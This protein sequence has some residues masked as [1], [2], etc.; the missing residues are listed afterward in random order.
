MSKAATA[1]TKT[2]DNAINF[3]RFMTLSFRDLSFG[4]DTM[5]GAPDGPT[6]DFMRGVIRWLTHGSVWQETESGFV[7]G[8]QRRTYSRI[9]EG[10][11]DSNS[12]SRISRSA[13]NLKPTWQPTKVIVCTD[14]I[15]VALDRSEERRVGKECRSRKLANQEKKKKKKIIDVYSMSVEEASRPGITR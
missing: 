4:R 3:L 6:A 9:M 2:A 7:V 14:P 8:L 11:T 10:P 1:V 12:L 15:S 5:D 13:E